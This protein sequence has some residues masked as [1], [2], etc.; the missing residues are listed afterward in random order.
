LSVQPGNFVVGPDENF[1][2]AGFSWGIVMRYESSK[3]TAICGFE[4]PMSIGNILD[5]KNSADLWVEAGY[6]SR[7]LQ[8][9]AETRILF[10]FNYH[11]F[12]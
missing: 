10:S 11:V 1:G 9:Q 3:K 5:D 8:L 7:L 12:T 4:L 2:L 6:Y